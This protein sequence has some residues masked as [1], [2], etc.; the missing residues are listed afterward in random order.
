M[1]LFN[2]RTSSKRNVPQI[3]RSRI[4]QSSQGDG[5]AAAAFIS[6]DTFAMGCSSPGL[7]NLFRS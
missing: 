1:M 6:P 4:S 7:L 5:E 3:A 2:R